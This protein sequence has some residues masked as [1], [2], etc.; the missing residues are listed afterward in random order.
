M[1]RSK[2]LDGEDKNCDSSAH[3]STATP[4]NANKHT[5]DILGDIMEQS[6]LYVG[7]DVHKNTIQ[8]SVMN[9]DGE[10]LSNASISNT[11][12][13]IQ[14]ALGGLSGMDNVKLVM[15]SSSVWKAPFHMMRDEMGLDVMLSNP[16]TTKLIATSKKKT[17][18]V[19][20][21]ILADM[22]RGGYIVSCHVSSMV[23]TNNR[24]LVRHRHFMVETR[25]RYKNVIHGILLQNS[26]K[27]GGTPF[28]NPWIAKIRSL[29]D[30][31]IEAYLSMIDSINDQI[32]RANIRIR[33]AVKES[34]DA[35]L[36]M[37][38]PGIGAYS[39]LTIAAEIDGIGRFNSAKKLCS[40][41]G[42]V[43]SVRSSGEKISYGKITRGGSNILRWIMTECVLTHVRYDS[44]SEISK[45]Y[46]RIA[47]KRG[48]GKAAVAAAAKM[49]RMIYWMLKKRKKY[50]AHYSQDVVCDE[51]VGG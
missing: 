11:K 27:P 42:I 35:Q 25:T 43:P 10:E 7:L 45:F 50:S 44:E 48:T 26:V 33:D 9:Q 29:K 39:A 40:Y 3:L 28:S 19:D 38:V 36:L 49:L 2:Q 16:Y 12:E 41:V 1:R 6:A 18:K 13:S 5:G 17:D 20:A 47:K 23:N 37:T 31:R 46:I 32:M 34:E 51:H 30:Y 4:E 22:L 24:N 14:G 21:H 15:E 8:I